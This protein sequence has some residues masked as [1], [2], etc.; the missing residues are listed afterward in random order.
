MQSPQKFQLRHVAAIPPLTTTS[1]DQQP[2]NNPTNKNQQPPSLLKPTTNQQPNPPKQ[3][4]MDQLHPPLPPKN[5]PQTSPVTSPI[6]P[7]SNGPAEAFRLVLRGTRRGALFDAPHGAADGGGDLSVGRQAHE[8]A[9][10]QRKHG[11]LCWKEEGA[12]WRSWGGWV[13]DREGV[14][15]KVIYGAKVQ[16][17]S[18]IYDGAELQKCLRKGL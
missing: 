18:R 8:V 14:R 7:V 16:E 12:G 9:K 13:E 15:V 1:Q 17:L 2:H 11:P 3:P 5:T 10:A 4:H 6:F